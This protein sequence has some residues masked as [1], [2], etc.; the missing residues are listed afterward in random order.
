LTAGRLS[1]ILNAIGP[2]ENAQV[3]QTR[4]RSRTEEEGALAPGH[5]GAGKEER[6]MRKSELL[7][8]TVAQ[9]RNLAKKLGMQGYSSLR[10]TDLVDKLAVEQR[11]SA[12]AGKRASATSKSKAAL[13][14]R[15]SAEKPEAQK[16]KDKKPRA[17]AARTE[18]K[19]PASRSKRVSPVAK[20]GFLRTG[21][22]E[23]RPARR[24]APADRAGED[25]DRT[26]GRGLSP[27]TRRAFS[28]HR[29]GGEERIKASKY[30]VGAESAAEVD[31]PFVFPESYG[32]SEIALMVRDPYWLFAYWEFAPDL[33]ADLTS[34][35]GEH[36][37]RNS[38]LV[39]RVY[40]VTDGDI[41]HA[42]SHHDIDVAPAARDWYINVMRIESDYQ[43]DI[44]LVLQDGSFILIARSNRVSLPPVGPSDE[45]DERWVTLESLDEIYHMT[46]RGP[47][48][49]GGWGSGGWG[50]R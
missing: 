12:R 50:R 31:Q 28:I 29:A 30:Y 47:S 3:A 41:E 37:L 2:G 42:V 8:M 45:V 32:E 26:A 49:G 21:S 19:K 34:R 16:V 38:R 13:K 5:G 33:E 15:K 24:A 6:V 9:L 36:A 44:G 40:D 14:P 10:K 4:L 18:A 35:I 17:A 22:S 11:R 7:D 1:T 39:L 25:A 48:S 27:R 46:E 20:A 23:N 43:I